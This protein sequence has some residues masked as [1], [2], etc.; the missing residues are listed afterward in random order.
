MELKYYYAHN[1]NKDDMTCQK[2]WFSVLDL[3]LNYIINHVLENNKHMKRSY[4]DTLFP[5]Q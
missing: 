3:N 1:V 5:L 4:D 2:C